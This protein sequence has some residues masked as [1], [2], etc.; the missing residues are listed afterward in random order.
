MWRRWLYGCEED[1]YMDDRELDLFKEKYIE[2]I[3]YIILHISTDIDLQNKVNHIE[4]RVNN[5]V[6]FH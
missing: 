2:L 6:N 3:K 5:F 4:S 1:G